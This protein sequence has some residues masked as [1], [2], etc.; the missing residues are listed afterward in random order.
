M[1]K[2][3]KL[4]N[5]LGISPLAK[6]L[7]SISNISSASFDELI[8]IEEI[9]DRIAMSIIDYFSDE[10]NCYIVKTLGSFGLN[11]EVEN[12]LQTSNIFEGKSFVISGVFNS[13]SRSELKE[14]IEMNG[15]KN[16][17]AV[18]MK[19]DYLIAGDKIGPSKL[20]KATDYKL[21]ILSEEDFI[22]LLNGKSN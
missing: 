18:S 3:L 4:S 13:F 22:L 10:R 14:I 20:K 15:G 21:N 1:S 2:V 5:L 16:I 17:T 12:K 8:A 9:G 11:M 7:K 19:T 6:S